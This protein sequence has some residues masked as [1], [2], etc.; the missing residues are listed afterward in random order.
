M[1]EGINELLFEFE[2]ILENIPRVVAKAAK[3]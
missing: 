2:K 3:C 1:K